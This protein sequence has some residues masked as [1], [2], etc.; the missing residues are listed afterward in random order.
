VKRL[1][2]IITRNLPP[3]TGGME[4]LNMH[5]L[6][7]LA[8]RYAVQV[9][10]PP[11]CAE[12][13]GPGV[14][15]FECRRS[16]AAAF[17]LE[18][19]WHVLGLVLGRQKPLAIIASSGLTAPLAW[20]AARLRRVPFVTFVYG[21]DL[22]ADHRAY[23]RIFIPAIRASSLVVAIS[24]NSAR[25]ANEKGVAQQRLRVLHPGVAWPRV[26]PSTHDFLARHALAERKLIL[27]VGRL[28]ARKGLAKFIAH[29][30]PAIVKQEPASLLVIIGGQASNALRRETSELDTIKQTVTTLG[31]EQHVLLLGV[32]SD[33]EV[34]A[35]CVAASAFIFPLI[36]VVGDIEG[37]G[38]AVAEAAAFGLPCIAFD[39]GG[40]ID[41]IRPDVTGRLI[42]RGDYGKF[43]EAV[44]AQLRGAGLD[45]AQCR[46]AART[47]AWP[48][49]RE[50][51]L[52]IMEDAFP[53]MPS[54]VET[55]VDG[56]R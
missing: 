4:R 16:S 17:L 33:A 53:E 11:G 47:F 35:A 52:E 27:S 15:C 6:D 41:A 32:V 14:Q 50:N 21:L 36:P 38:M 31:L 48:R 39:E 37:F 44:L 3:M 23:Q 12:Y 51:L 34:A 54:S 22:V 45:R 7:V 26:L 13:L 46:D 43:A 24:E 55:T 56:K 49:Y 42:A 18:S 25:I 29:A 9:I 40:V 28:V 19:L 1:L 5:M 20:L 2:V 10:G 8:E 30:L